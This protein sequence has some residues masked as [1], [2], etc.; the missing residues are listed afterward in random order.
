M[1]LCWPSQVSTPRLMQTCNLLL[2]PYKGTCQPNY[3]RGHLMTCTLHTTFH[4]Q[5]L[6]GHRCWWWRIYRLTCRWVFCGRY[7]WRS[8]CSRCTP[9][10]RSACR[11]TCL[12]TPDT[13]VQ[14]NLSSSTWKSEWRQWD[15]N[16]H[17]LQW[18]RHPCLLL[19][20]QPPPPD[21][22]PCRVPWLPTARTGA[23]PGR[24]GARVTLHPQ[25]TLTPC[26]RVN[27]EDGGGTV[28]LGVRLNWSPHRLSP[29]S[30]RL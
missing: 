25:W 5:F 24:A 16:R 14:A 29:A 27:N 20:L 3:I 28:M 26:G 19:L 18:Q 13:S 15:L 7:V 22:T 10:C 11:W 9:E 8:R 4:N 30:R 23:W 2:P 1:L 12:R 6:A 17:R 21:V